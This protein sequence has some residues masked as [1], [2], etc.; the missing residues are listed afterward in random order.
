MF[1]I[2]G[3][4]YCK[5]IVLNVTLSRQ[6][7]SYQPRACD[8]DFCLKHGAS[9]LSDAQGALSIQVKQ[10]ELLGRFQQE[11]DDI[12]DF[13]YCKKCGVLVGV[14]HTEGTE[15]FGA[16]NSS[17]IDQISFGEKVSVS[18]QKLPDEDKIKR[19]KDVWFKNV[20]L[21]R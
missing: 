14:I 10:A 21:T 6:P 13:L 15:T 16:V 11:E 18:P 9:Y 20:E 3:S 19:W 5:N 12:A 7:E 4:C 1:K 17:V 8:C 2:Q